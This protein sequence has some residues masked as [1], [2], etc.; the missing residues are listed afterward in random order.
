VSEQPGKTLHDVVVLGGG[1]GGYACALRAAQL[2]LDVVL[3]EKGKLGGTCLHQGCIPTKALLH[4]AEIADLAREG[5]QF[6]VQSTVSGIDMPAVNAYK[7]GVISRLYKGLQG[8]VKSRKITYVE[9]SGRM[10]RPDTVAVGDTTYTGRNVVLATGSIPRSLPGLDIDGKRVISSDHALAMDTIPKSVVILGGGVIGLEFAS[11]WKSFGADVTIVEALPHLLP[12]EDE[13][14]SNQVERQYRR[15]GIKAELGARFSKAEEVDQGVVVHLENGTQIEAE[16][17]LVAIGR[18]PVSAGLGFDDAGVAMERGFVTV[19][20]YCRTNVPN[21]Y[22]VG[23]V[24]PTLQLAHVGFGEGILVAEQIA[25]L[26][27]RPIDYDGVPRVT[28]SE[29]EVASIGLTEAAAREKHGDSV[30]TVK[31]DLAGNGKSQILKTSGIVKLVALR[32]GPVIGIHM[33]GSRVS[34]LLAEGQL[35][36]NW[37]AYADDVATLIHP[38]PTQSEA[39]GEAHLALAGKP[40]HA[41]S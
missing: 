11:V 33:V 6:G 31:Y 1:S 4:T 3:I 30:V 32:D 19:D 38:H 24:I 36:F 21:V 39:M 8:L 9:G 20:E 14:I 27:P 22:A 37:E 40:L 7:D 23:D 34:E 2:G 17:M 41:H 25:G 5:E 10:I 35:I 13:E 18:G 29:P 28:Y 26:D 12:L 15:R 16:L